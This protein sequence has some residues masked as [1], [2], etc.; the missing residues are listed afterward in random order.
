MTPKDKEE[1]KIKK[2]KNPIT[3]LIN[4]TGEPDSGK[5]TFAMTS[6][7][8]PER[9]IFVDDDVKG[10][11]IVDAIE[12]SHR[13]F[14][15]YHNLVK[16]SKGMRELELHELCLSIIN[17][18]EPNKYDVLI[19]DT[20]TRFENTFHPVV[21]SNPNKFKQF[22]SA[23]GQIKGA[24]QWGA[25]FD[26]EASIIDTLLDK[27]PLVILT[28]H[29]KKDA[30]KREIAES[31]K[32][33]IQ[34]ARMRVWLRHSDSPIPTA[35]MLKRL[36]KIEV[37]DDGI[38]PS[39]VTHR[40]VK[41][42]TWKRLLEYWNNPVGNTLPEEDE[43]L[44]E[45]ELSILDGVLTRDQ[46]DALRLAVIEAEKEQELEKQLAELTKD[47]PSGGVAMISAALTKYGF[48]IDK[49]AELLGKDKSKVIKEYQ[50]SDWDI[51]Q[52]AGEK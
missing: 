46:K 19:W 7:A 41:N 12:S 11:S 14:G 10:K 40:K 47:Y 1:I 34:K 48:D 9:T 20:W 38:I 27:V 5:T 51:I 25:A 30:M 15:I 31:K 50:V 22:Y 6:G 17:E 21:A 32:P 37:T 43:K 13:K 36:E 49:V 39:N 29:L 16:E 8:A 45:F 35:L 44:N 3:G 28:S 24:E 2:S 52:K 33:L 4:P 42:F 26:Y 18:I 23:M